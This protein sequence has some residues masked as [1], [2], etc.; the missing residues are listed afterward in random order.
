MTFF[1]SR[2]IYAENWSSILINLSVCIVCSTDF[3]D[4]CSQP[5]LTSLGPRSWTA[6]VV[7]WSQLPW[8]VFVVEWIEPGS[9]KSMSWLKAVAL[10]RI[11]GLAELLGRQ[12]Q[13]IEQFLRLFYLYA[14]LKEDIIAFVIRSREDICR[15][16]TVTLCAFVLWALVRCSSDS[17][18][19]SYLPLL[20]SRWV[21]LYTVHHSSES[22][23][24]H[25]PLSPNG[26]GR[27]N[28][29]ALPPQ[30]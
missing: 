23:F 18:T 22:P 21:Y 19:R 30:F 29:S 17:V 25:S 3:G 1:I 16:N 28:N 8:H 11:P 15:V 20:P 14:Q 10:Q 13:L 12:A 24:L 7:R 9:H 5:Y 27:G 2:T 4:K 26:A 6:N